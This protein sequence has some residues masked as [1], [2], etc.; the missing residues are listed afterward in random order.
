MWVVFNYKSKELQT[1]KNS[2]FKILGGTPEFYSPKIKYE[3]YI[4]NKRKTFEKNILNNYVICNHHKF[5]NSKFINLLKNC[6]GLNYFLSGSEYN[7]N[8]LEKFVTFCKN[9]EDENGFLKQ[10]FFTVTKKNKGK[11]ISGPFTQMIFDI[12]EE[13]EKKIRILLNNVNVT[14]S[15]QS[16]NLLYSYI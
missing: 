2:F 6:K 8:E 13:K 15:K 11:F 9:N 10:S 1:L 14:I 3:K 5:S 16:K 7:Q 4:N 12:I